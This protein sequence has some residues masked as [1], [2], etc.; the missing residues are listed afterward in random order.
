MTNPSETRLREQLA[1]LATD[2][3][4][5]SCAEQLARANSA[6]DSLAAQWRRDVARINAVKDFCRS[7][8]DELW[9]KRVMEILE[10]R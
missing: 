9:A 5:D 2:A 1:H 3:G 10:G 4:P 7:C 8:A 6:I